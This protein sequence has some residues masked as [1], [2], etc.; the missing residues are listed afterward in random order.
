MLKWK[1][2]RE[3]KEY[4]IL[5]SET[6]GCVKFF[7]ETKR[8]VNPHSQAKRFVRFHSKMVYIKFNSETKRYVG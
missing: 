2:L 8:N 7:S 3:T 5:Q 4:V 6:I 1:G